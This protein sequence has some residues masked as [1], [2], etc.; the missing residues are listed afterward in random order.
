MNR[1]EQIIFGTLGLVIAACACIAAWVVVPQL[2]QMYSSLTRATP[3]PSN[4]PLSTSEN[5]PTPTIANSLTP[6]IMPP[7]PPHTS[8][9][10]VVVYWDHDNSG[11]F[12]S[13][14]VFLGATLELY[15]GSSCSGT[16]RATPESFYLFSKLPAG[17]YCVKV[18]NNS[19]SNGPNCTLIPGV[20]G[21]TKVY[22]LGV[23][24]HKRD[25]SEG[26][27]YICQ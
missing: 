22:S 18:F 24:E 16:V 14:D 19:L 1:K 23:N 25:E 27:P 3:L 6:T 21:N 15:A 26:F 5:L 8:S 2:Q 9:I 17:T 4:T 7:T 20:Y 12:D 13:G 11:I 10:L